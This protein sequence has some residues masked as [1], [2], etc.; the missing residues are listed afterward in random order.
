MSLPALSKKFLTRKNLSLYLA[1][2]SAILLAISAIGSILDSQ[3]RKKKLQDFE[4]GAG[5]PPSSSST[6][7]ELIFAILQLAALVGFGLAL[8]TLIEDPLKLK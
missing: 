7:T 2:P 4:S 5:S 8:L 3:D 6:H 1:V